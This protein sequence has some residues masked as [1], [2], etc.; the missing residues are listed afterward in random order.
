MAVASNAKQS[1][2]NEKDA[3]ACRRES[4]YV[5]TQQ[6]FWR[7]FGLISVFFALTTTGCGEG[8]GEE[9]QP[10]AGNGGAGMIAGA[11]AGAGASGQGAGAGGMLNAAGTRSGEDGGVLLA[12]G[13]VSD[14]GKGPKGPNTK[15]G[16]VNLA[17]SLGAPLDPNGGAALSPP[18]PAGWVWYPIDGAL[19]R[20]GS[21]TGFYVRFTESDKL[22]MYLEGGGAC[23]SPGFCNYNPAHVGQILSGDG[24]TVIGSTFG[25]TPTRQQPGAFA[26]GA[27]QGAFDDSNAENP[28]KGWNQIYI[29]YCTGDVHFGTRKDVTLPGVT[30]KQQF[31]GYLN[32]QKFVARIVPTFKDKVD[33]VVITGASAGG[34]GAALNFSMV[35]DAFG[36][37][38]VYGLDDSGP[39]FIDKYMPVCMQKRWREI[40]GLDAALPP[41]CT[42]CFHT[43]G[44]GILNLADFLLEKHPNA[45]IAMIS[46]MNDEVIRLFF[47][48]GLKDC[49]SF[50]TADPVAITLGQF[51]PAVYMVGT[52]YAAGLEQL[53][54]D[55]VSTGRLATYF[56]GG[57]NIAFHQHIWR[58]RFYEMPSG[59]LTIAQFVTKFLNDEIVQIGP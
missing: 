30:N 13:A 23:S 59:D 28:F 9:A 24:Q 44:G 8:A 16:Y 43:D 42:E 35:Q 49:A 45:T 27:L 48:S 55:Y 52:D 33:K 54:A 37:V 38:R 2:A 40:W 18:P 22:L 36:E 12:D 14:G 4:A 51:D 47:S 3:Q 7:F 56:I 58:P 32:M 20:D 57:A 6:F 19:C 21:P 25:T 26:G 39:P 15:P 41:D 53:R 1:A 10:T 34:F 11:A 46:S 31:V 5:R 50:E 29:P 17:P